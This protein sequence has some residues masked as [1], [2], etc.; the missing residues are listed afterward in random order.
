MQKLKHKVNC[1]SCDS[2]NLLEK[3]IFDIDEMI[4]CFN[5]HNLLNEII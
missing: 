4:F 5:C 2:T 3:N 1:L